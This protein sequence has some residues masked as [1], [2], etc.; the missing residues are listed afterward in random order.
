MCSVRIVRAVGF[1]LT[2]SLV[3]AQNCFDHDYGAVLGDGDEVVFPISAI[4]FSFP[5]GG[6]TWTHAH[7]CTNGYLTLSNGGSPPPP[8]PDYAAS[9]AELVE[10]APRI[11]PFW[12]DLDALAS[13]GG[14]VWFRS[15]PAK[16]VVTWDRVH[17][18][19]GGLPAGS[20]MSI[21]V[22]LFPSGQ[23]TFHY[24]DTVTN[25]STIAGGQVALVGVSPGLGVS[26]PF[27]RN[28]ST[29]G[30]TSDQTLFE[31]WSVQHTFDLAGKM[32]HLASGAP[33]W[34]WTPLTP[35]NCASTSDFGAGC[36][37][38][39]A[40]PTRPDSLYE[41]MSPAQFDLANTSIALLRTSDGYYAISMPV[42]FIAPSAGA[43]IVADD[44]D[45]IE[46]VALSAP[47]SVPGGTTSNLTIGSNG[48]VAVAASGNGTFYTPSAAA[49]LDWPQ[50]AFACWHD[51]SP[52]AGGGKVVFEEVGGVACVTWNGVWSFNTTAADTWQ[53][54]FDLSSG[55]V[56]LVFAVMTPAGGSYLVGYSRGGT[57]PDP[58]ASDL[59]TVL[60]TGVQLHDPRVAL[61][62]TS[63]GEPFLGN[64]QWALGVA[65]VPDVVPLGIVFWGTAALPA[66]GLDLAWL[67]M[68]GCALHTSADL[69][70]SAFPIDQPQGTGAMSWPIPVDLTLL[71]LSVATQCFAF[72]LDTPFNLI[73]SNGT[74]LTF[75]W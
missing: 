47:M 11:A 58:G 8:P 48:Y 70:S 36:L 10:Q 29:A 22:Q 53:M 27:S 73:A 71:N 62:M 63:L 50:T 5:L 32:L 19:A 64:L 1:A 6:Q 13:S 43:V 65:N 51:Y 54:Q 55:Q 28:L 16:C 30:S 52:V 46:T 39:P 17:N 24:S 23:V 35:V 61:T 49:F 67:G 42:A 57:S 34:S 25:A 41:L 69:F 38:L 21:Q 72:S 4:G 15:S 66:P 44:D 75:G 14:K 68:P 3:F 2:S 9:V 45:A 40:S 31:T 37:D 26:V 12:N 7:V 59:S 18:Y 20:E 60:A 33:G 56:N 74:M